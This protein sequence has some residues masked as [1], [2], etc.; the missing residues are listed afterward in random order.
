ME[1]KLT[2]MDLHLISMARKLIS[3]RYD[4]ERHHIGSALLTDGGDIFTG[5][6]VEAS[7]GRIALCAEAV[8]IGRMRTEGS[9]MVD[10]IVAVRS[11]RKGSPPGRIEVV[12]PCGMCRELIID[13]GK[14]ARVILSDDGSTKKVDAISLLPSRF[15]PADHGL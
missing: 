12:S 1:E 3:R 6:H 7:V 14:G 13:Y 9:G 5:V 2:D 4:A 15:M 8:A 11:P 10:T